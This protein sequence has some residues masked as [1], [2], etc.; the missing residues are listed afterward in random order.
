VPD[1]LLTFDDLREYHIRS[2]QTLARRLSLDNFP[3]P[4]HL[5]SSRRLYWLRVDI[6]RW[7]REQAAAQRYGDAR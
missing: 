7:A 5:G 4:F 6:E 1:D 3:K 2:R